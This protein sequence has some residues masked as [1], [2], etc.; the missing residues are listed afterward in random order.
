MSVLLSG[1]R[2]D[3]AAPVRPGTARRRRILAWSAAGILFALYAALALQRH[4]QLLTTGYDLGIFEQEVRSYA[5]WSPPTSLLKGTDYPLLGDH[6]SPIVATI[7]PF[8][9]LLPGPQTLLVAQAAL[10][11]TGVVPLV[12]WASRRLGIGAGVVV[13]GV[14]GLAGGIV[15]AIDFD[16]HEIAFAVPLLALSLTALGRRRTGAAIAWAL[17]LVLVKEDLGL[18]VAA[19]GIL[20]A[21]RAWRGAGRSPRRR[22]ELLLGFGAIALGVAATLVETFLIIPAFNPAGANAYTGQV[23]TG[24][25]LASLADPVAGNARIA[26]T[27]LLLLP[28]AFVALRS[29]LVLAML[30]TL[31]WRFLSD[32]PAYWSMDFHYGAV[33]VPIV[34]AAFVDGLIR[35]QRRD[36]VSARRRWP[37]L[38]AALT[39]ILLAFSPLAQLAA[40]SFWRPD[41]HVVAARQV[42]ERIPDGATV[43]ASNALVPQLTARAEVSQIGVLPIGAG[44][45]DYV[46]ADVRRQSYPIT[47]DALEDAVAEAENA[48]GYRVLAEDDDV[49]LLARPGL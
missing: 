49:T 43:A 24:G 30:P 22:G 29:P 35:I 28:T 38:A 15:H 33:L 7:A 34:T 39:A 42:L 25:V 1:P 21:A 40:P 19:V 12:L 44:R 14:Y 9:A 47:P 20:A 27:V 8:Y 16:F 10:M 26:T 3:A 6:F 17:P 48:Y 13:A 32:N 11:A 5:A 2:P 31:A 46:V 37:A 36:P 18:T 4:A 23:S 41:A 45:P